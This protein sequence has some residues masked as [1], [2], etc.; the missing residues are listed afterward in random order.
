MSDA[1]SAYKAST[2]SDV[3]SVLQSIID[4][5]PFA[6]NR[7]SR[8]ELITIMLADLKTIPKGRIAQKDTALA[9]LALKT[10]GK[11]P[12]GSNIISYSSSLATL[13]NLASSLA[14]EDP[15]ASNEALRCVANALLL[16]ESGRLS[17]LDKE[18][19]G[20]DICAVMLDVS[21]LKLFSSLIVAES[22]DYRSNFHSLSHL[23]SLYSIPN[24]LYQVSGPRQA[25]WPCYRRYHRKQA[26]HGHECYSL[27]H[28]NV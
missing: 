5:P 13:L 25:K 22:N 4:A 8:T 16:H 11:H 2:K 10:V 1:L 27:R 15:D 9:L 18:A 12:Q 6:M 21:K 24:T 23:V 14:K 26:R 3:V 28:E 7:G 20:G 17:I 19:N